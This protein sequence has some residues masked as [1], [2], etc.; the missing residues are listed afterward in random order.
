MSIAGDLTSNVLP[1]FMLS[2]F[3]SPFVF[4]AWLDVFQRRMCSRNLVHPLLPTL[5]EQFML[6]YMSTIR[7]HM[8]SLSLLCVRV[9]YLGQT[10]L[11][12]LVCGSVIDCNKHVSGIAVQV[13]V[14][15]GMQR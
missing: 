11:P 4:H 12:S 9:V 3:Y 2:N 13:R 1:F 6:V 10:L 15:T 14:S 8:D 5:T 7:L